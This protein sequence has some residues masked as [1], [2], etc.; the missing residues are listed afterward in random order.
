VG[1]CGGRGTTAAAM[2]V[3]VNYELAQLRM[4]CCDLCEYCTKITS[5][6]QNCP[7]AVFAICR[8]HRAWFKFPPPGHCFLLIFMSLLF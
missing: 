7:R 1:H 2:M 5:T 3:I 6:W 8:Y 4:C